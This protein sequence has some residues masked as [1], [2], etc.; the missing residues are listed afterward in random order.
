MAKGARHRAKWSLA[1]KKPGTTEGE[2]RPGSHTTTGHYCRRQ[3]RDTRVDEARV[4][5]E[6]Q[7]K[8]RGGQ[9]CFGRRGGSPPPPSSRAPS[10]CPATVLQR[11]VPG[12]MVFVT[13]SN[14]PQPLRQPPPTACLTASGAASEVPSLL[15]HPWGGGSTAQHSTAQWKAPPPPRTSAQCSQHTTETQKGAQGSGEAG[16]QRG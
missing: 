10:L 1:K 8:G 15:M 14:R 3:R 9:G 2:G 16:K 5:G 6:Q 11:H 7:Y 4:A 13:D 12:S